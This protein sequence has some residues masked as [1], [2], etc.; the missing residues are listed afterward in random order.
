M[1]KINII[2]E[3]DGVTQ[4]SN[5]SGVKQ[6][7]FNSKTRRKKI[8]EADN[9]NKSGNEFED[10]VQETQDNVND[11]IDVA[12]W[13]NIPYKVQIGIRK[14]Q[15]EFE[16]IRDEYDTENRNI[17]LNKLW[18][19]LSEDEQN[20]MISLLDNVNELVDN[21]LNNFKES[22][23]LTEEGKSKFD[24]RTN[25]N[26]TSEDIMAD[27]ERMSNEIKKDPKGFKKYIKSKK[28]L[29]KN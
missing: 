24:R 23:K 19:L 16:K 20:T 22:Y 4:P 28:I 29:D 12:E 10:Y 27:I 1:D 21:N 18:N 14:F 26:D 17:P 8:F 15:N 5:V 2:K 9:K 13:D 6:D 11:Y 3:C 7:I 25:I